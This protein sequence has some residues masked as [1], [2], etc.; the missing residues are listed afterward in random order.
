MNECQSFAQAL[1]LQPTHN[2]N[3]PHC[4]SRDYHLLI[5]KQVAVVVVF[6]NV[7]KPLRARFHNNCT[8]D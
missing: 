5:S 3:V 4:K 6:H 2:T 8:V 1:S 7:Q